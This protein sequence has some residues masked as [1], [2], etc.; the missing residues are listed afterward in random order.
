MDEDVAMVGPESGTYAAEQ[1]DAIAKAMW[2]SFV[3]NI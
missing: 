2:E 1:R 3:S